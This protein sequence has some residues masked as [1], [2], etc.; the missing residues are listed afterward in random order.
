MAQ[1]KFLIEANRKLFET[2]L[3]LISNKF[4]LISDELNLVEEMFVL[5][6]LKYLFTSA[7]NNFFLV[8]FYL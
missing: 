3:N 1:I 5:F 2:K 4:N 6:Y 7:A 8:T